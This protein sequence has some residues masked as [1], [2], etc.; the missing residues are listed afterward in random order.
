MRCTARRGSLWGVPPLRDT[1]LLPLLAFALPACPKKDPP[2]PILEE[3][4][5]TV[6]RG[7]DVVGA[8]GIRATVVGTLQ[9]ITPDGLEG[10][11]TAVVLDDGTPIFLS[12]APP[13]E[14]LTWLLGSKVRVQGTLWEKSPSGW[15]VAKLLDAEAPMPADVSILLTP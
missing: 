6:L 13:T 1:L 14:T 15:P 4:T 2:A 3:A 7:P 5:R 12:E 9:K 11:G 8:A 10:E